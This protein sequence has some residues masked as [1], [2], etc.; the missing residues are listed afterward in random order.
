MTK[1]ENHIAASD[2]LQ[3]DTNRTLDAIVGIGPSTAQ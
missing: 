2:K 1:L 3:S